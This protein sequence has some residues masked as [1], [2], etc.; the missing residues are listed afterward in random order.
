MK[1][2]P[3]QIIT[4]PMR[5]KRYLSGLF[6][7]TIGLVNQ[8]SPITF[9][10]ALSFIKNIIS[11]HLVPSIQI[12]TKLIDTE[13]IAEAWSS[14]TEKLS[15]CLP[16]DNPE[17]FLHGDQHALRAMILSIALLASVWNEYI[18]IVPHDE[19]PIRVTAV[20]IGAML[21]DAW[22]TER[23]PSLWVWFGEGWMSRRIVR[24]ILE[25][26][27]PSLAQNDLRCSLIK[28]ALEAI[29]RHP[30]PWKRRIPPTPEGFLLSTADT[31]LQFTLPHN[32]KRNDGR[33][34]GIVGLVAGVFNQR[35]ITKGF[36]GREQ[37]LKPPPKFLYPRRF[38]PFFSALYKRSLTFFGE[39]T[40]DTLR[41]LPV[42]SP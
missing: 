38:D 19:L 42:R 17:V 25:S 23:N 2:R 26:L 39:L 3:R 13:L 28:I 32:I 15:S 12:D 22:L 1:D 37:G 34:R 6:Q 33:N 16:P 7:A 5:S 14:Y 11:E 8:T 9:D 31:L 21:H 10:D 29:V 18:A 35:S 30:G 40:R 27:Q 20:L 4:Y 36:K 24:R 41:Y